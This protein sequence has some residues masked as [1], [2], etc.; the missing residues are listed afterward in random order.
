MGCCSAA[1]RR[2]GRGGGVR[3]VKALPWECSLFP[4][5]L[6]PFCW[7]RQNCNSSI[8]IIKKINMLLFFVG[9]IIMYMYHNLNEQVI[10][11]LI[12]YKERIN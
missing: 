2:F 10:G 5:P 4:S 12:Y 3:G 1:M 7:L 8:I 9:T 6:L 11:K